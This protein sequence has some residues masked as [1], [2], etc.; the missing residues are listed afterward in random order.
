MAT[1]KTFRLS[2]ASDELY[3]MSDAETRGIIEDYLR[4]FSIKSSPASV[5]IYRNNLKIFMCWNYRY[6]DN[7]PFIKINKR[8]FR[9]FF[10]FGTEEMGWGSSRYANVWS[11]LNS[12]SEWLENNYDDVYPD[13]KNNIKKIDKIPRSYVREKT[14][15]TKRELDGLLKW[16]GE[17]NRI[18][19]QCLLALIMSSGMRIS[20][21]LRM[22]TDLID[23]NN[24]AY[25]GLFYETTKQIKTKGRGRNGK[26]LYK[27]LII[28]LFKPYYE[29]WLPIRK[30]IMDEKLQNHDYIFIR[31]DG[32][33]AQV[34]TVRGWIEDWDT[35]LN[36]KHFYPHAGRHFWTSYL[37]S[38]G[39]EKQLI[40]ELQGWASDTLVDLYND[41]TSKDKKWESLDNLRLALENDKL[42]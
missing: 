6:N 7:T 29:K 13:F 28:D 34:S 25:N 15:F 8:Q 39:L 22:T 18:Q 9:S 42:F 31:Q 11:T 17:N 40:Q 33:P 26:P 35:P 19:E 23:D 21:T 16:L 37:D 3:N 1:R 41:N 5:K 24:T 14:I 38:L 36:G 27:Y 4:D 12:F 32:K 2:I 20:E 30:K 10:L